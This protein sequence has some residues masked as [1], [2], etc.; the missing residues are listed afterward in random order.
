MNECFFKSEKSGKHRSCGFTLVELL[1]TIAIIGVL[2]ALLL[3][4][5]QAA[6]ESARQTQ[7]RN[8]L[9]QISLAVL[10][11]ESAKGFLPPSF[12]V[13]TG[14]DER[15]NWSLHAFLLPYI[16][17]GA[18]FAKIDPYSDWH[19]QLPS[20]IPQLM[21]PFYQCPSEVHSFP[22]QLD[23][24]PY[25]A[26]TNYGFNMGRWFIYDPLTGQTGD[27]AFRVERNTRLAE[28]LDGTSNTL[29]VA[30]VKTYTSYFRNTNIIPASMPQTPADLADLTGVYHLG[31][32]IE[33]NTGHT[34]WPDG[35]VHHTGFTTTFTPNS[36]VAYTHGDRTYDVN[37]TTQQEGRG[38]DRPT[39][40]AITS[41]S[42]HRGLVNVAILDGSVTSM[43][44]EVA[45]EIWQA[46]ST[47]SGGEVASA[48]P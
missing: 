45:V 38:T 27:G 21:I 5:I 37:V 18:A 43:A 46:L 23:G 14:V 16:E 39:L 33:Q 1:V 41:R 13:R 47:I 17:G 34:V 19:T 28:V 32:S 15:G 6:R 35:R 7:C 8:N 36:N 24:I 12:R 26:P 40:A 25:V 48:E 20:G 44:N 11:S 3:P 2:M 9:R 4:A 42:H 29:A 31:P 10:H 30:E 22:R